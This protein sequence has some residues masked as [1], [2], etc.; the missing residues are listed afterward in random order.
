M[1]NKKPI[2]IAEIKTKSMY[3][4]ESKYNRKTLIDTALRYGDWISVHTD[5]RFGGSFDDIYMIRRETIKPILAK[6]FHN[7]I[8]D[9]NKCLDLGADYVLRVDCI[10][11][12]SRNNDAI[13]NEVS[14]FKDL[15]NY[16]NPYNNKI[17]EKF[18][19]NGR[20]LKTGIGKKYIGD[21]QE[22]RKQCKWL[23]GTSLLQHPRDVKLYYPNCDAFIVGQNLVEF[24][25]EL[26]NGEKY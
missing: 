5:P 19:Y 25:R 14:S 18:V 16:K 2:F 17:E 3:G 15:D 23:C 13:L 12:F 26:K 20:N 21:Y 6:G 11:D 1:D 24:C 9:I 4:F 22:Y 10:P 8:D 7:H